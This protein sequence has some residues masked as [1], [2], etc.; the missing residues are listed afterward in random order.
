MI[1]PQRR[2]MRESED[3]DIVQN[4]RIRLCLH[5]L[6]ALPWA[7]ISAF[8]SWNRSPRRSEALRNLSTQRMTQ[9]SSLDI[10]LLDVKSVTQSV[11]QRWTRLEY[12]C[13]ASEDGQLGLTEAVFAHARVG[14]ADVRA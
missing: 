6:M 10:R 8:F 7:A 11:K 14:R 2:A 12:I 9:P 4:H 3:L 13:R 1:R 5:L